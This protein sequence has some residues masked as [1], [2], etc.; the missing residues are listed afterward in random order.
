MNKPTSMVIN[1]FCYV[2]LLV[3]LGITGIYYSAWDGFIPVYFL[4]YALSIG[5][6]SGVICLLFF[7]E[8]IIKSCPVFLRFL[9]FFVCLVGYV[10]FASHV[11]GIVDFSEPAQI[12][13]MLIMIGIIFTAVWFTNL[14]V[15]KQ[16]EKEFSIKL[17]EFNESFED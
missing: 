1:T 4:W 12:L 14:W 3:L 6:V 9:F 16:Q 5:A 2:F 11:F 13:Q 10:A 17:N 15:F 7:T 8:K